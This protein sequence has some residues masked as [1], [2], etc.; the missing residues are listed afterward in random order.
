MR[1]V[2]I[3][4][5]RSSSR[6]VVIA[7]AVLLAVAG[8]RCSRPTPASN[9]PPV[10]FNK[11]VAPILF[12]N[13]APCHRPGE[14]APFSLLS[15]ADAVKHADAMGAET[16]AR[17]MPPWLPDHGE[18]PIEGERRLRDDQIDVIQ[19]WVKTG[20]VEGNPADLP[21]APV[22]PEGW[23]LGKPDVVLTTPAYT[24]KPS[25]EDVYRDLVIRTSL[26]SDAYVRAVEFKTNGA[27][28]HH[29]VIRVDTSQSSRRRDG[30]DGQPG[31]SGMSGQGVQDPEGNFIGWAPG[32]GPIVSPE[33]MPWLLNRGA[34]LVIELHMIPSNSSAVIQPTLGLFLA[35]T[36]PVQTPITLKMSSKMIDIAA[37]QRDFVTTDSF[38]LP[39]PMDLLSVYPHAHYLGKEMTVTA[40][41]P[42]GTTKT[43][44]HIPQWSFHWQQDYR[45]VTP[46][47]LPAGTTITMRYTYDNSDNNEDN[48]H[49][50]P[51][52]V[53]FG[54]KSTDE[55]AE[56]GLQVLPKSLSDAA[57]LVQSLV[58]HDAAANVTLAQAQVKESPNNAAYQAYLGASYV[59]VGRFADA[60]TPLEAAIRLDPNAASA[61]SDLG[62]VLMSLGRVSDAI[63]HLQR[64]VTLAP[65][66]EMMYFN[67]G[68]ALAK[69]SRPNEAAV[70][71][72]KAIALNPEFPDA[73]VNLGSL[74][75][76][77]GRVK[78]ALPHFARAVELQ[79]N[80]AVVHTDYSSA[81]AASGR[82]PEAMQQ[83]RRALELNPDYRP[84][85]DNFKRLQQ[86]GIR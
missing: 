85:Q 42:G 67:L 80:S 81:L 31:F 10:T 79:P 12:S 25:T 69:T 13:C 40:T 71:Y 32:R 3:V 9:A 22:F 75:F 15:Y 57:R 36:P 63:G 4:N 77:L 29:A 54:G 61:E 52:R 33:G 35:A 84:A 47:S 28:I 65:K 34:D 14:V 17:R 20:K 44:I 68:N 72:E 8:A 27:P 82:L 64:A 51:V 5:V 45:Y 39:A 24:L 59:E 86:M 74:L 26:K 16:L 56:L 6:V 62:T 19:R 58:D 70:A 50:P 37:G 11:D 30:E 66:N 2:R 78:D 38:L 46:I 1:S 76:D 43:L 83:V 18:F 7:S 60:V 73:H 49:H 41:L 48:P 21:A 23:R 53:R 55:M